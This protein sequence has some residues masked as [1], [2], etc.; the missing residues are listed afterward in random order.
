MATKKIEDENKEKLFSLKHVDGSFH[1]GKTTTLGSILIILAFVANFLT[2]NYIFK[3]T[4]VTANSTDMT[5]IIEK[6]C[7]ELNSRMDK[8]DSLSIERNRMQEVI[9]KRQELVIQLLLLHE[10]DI[11]KI[12]EKVGVP[13]TQPDRING[14]KHIKDV[15]DKDEASGDIIRKNLKKRGE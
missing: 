4:A 8:S 13:K 12:A 9:L 14:I 6:T 11:G 7:T 10:E 15:I 2:E 5:K 1:Y 3:P